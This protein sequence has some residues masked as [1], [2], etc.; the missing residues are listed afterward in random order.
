MQHLRHFFDSQRTTP[1]RIMLA[2]ETFLDEEAHTGNIVSSLFTKPG[3]GKRPLLPEQN[4]RMH[5]IKLD[6]L[7]FLDPRQY[8]IPPHIRPRGGIQVH[9][10]VGQSAL[11]GEQVRER[12][13]QVPAYF[14]TTSAKFRAWSRLLADSTHSQDP[15]HL[16]L[17]RLRQ[18]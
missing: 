15:S 10:Y 18:W 3:T 7:L 11:Q 6:S 2:K 4:Y 14:K 1:D 16:D 8:Y 5:T 13:D 17:G 12:T 9:I